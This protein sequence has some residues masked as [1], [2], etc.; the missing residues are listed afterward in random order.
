[1]V[2]MWVFGYGSLTWRPGFPYLQRVVGYISGYERRFWQNSLPCRGAP[3]KPG[4]VPLLVP[5]EDPNA[6]VWGTAYEIPED[7][8]APIRAQLDDRERLYTN[9]K[10]L[11]VY[12]NNHRIIVSSALVYIGHNAG[13]DMPLDALAQHIADCHGTRGSNADYLFKLAEFMRSEVPDETDEHL[14]ALEAQVKYILEKR[15][16]IKDTS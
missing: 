9:R 14:F 16:N 13:Y 15:K 3:D 6:R 12:D 1:F 8:E 4:R 10:Y 7:Q 5:S 11:S 2:I